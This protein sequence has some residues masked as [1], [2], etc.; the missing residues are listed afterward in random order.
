VKQVRFAI[1][2]LAS[3]AQPLRARGVASVLP[4]PELEPV[5]QP[6]TAKIEIEIKALR[7][8]PLALTQHAPAGKS[9]SIGPGFLAVSIGNRFQLRAFLLSL[10]WPSP[11]SIELSLQ[12]PDDK[13]RA[14]EVD[15]STSAALADH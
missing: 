3:T 8:M 14:A 12:L 11:H 9:F 10:R 6:A 1:G 7:S 4:S 13:M 15:G 5:S 2:T